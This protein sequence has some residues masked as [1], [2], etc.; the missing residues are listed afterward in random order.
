MEHASTPTQLKQILIRIGARRIAFDGI[1]GAGKSHLAR[2]L[3]TEFGL[4]WIEL[5]RYLMPHQDSFVPSLRTKQLERDL[6]DLPEF[7]IDGICLLQVLEILR[8]ESVTVVYVKRM[9]NSKWEDKSFLVPCGTEE[10]HVA[11]CR[12]NHE[13]IV[14]AT[15]DG[16]SFALDEEIIRYHARYRPHQRASICYERNAT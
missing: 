12:L 13:Q 16:R 11:Q 15:G 14:K 5:D 2:E 9:C 1:N 8:V 3:K 6:V 10:E 7:V 4:T